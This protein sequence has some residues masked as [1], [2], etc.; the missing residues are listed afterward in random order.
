MQ[1]SK[2]E[3]RAREMEEGEKESGCGYQTRKI[4]FVLWPRKMKQAL[5]PEGETLRTACTIATVV[6]TLMY[7]M[8]IAVVGFTPTVVN[9]INAAFAYSCKLTLRER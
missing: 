3:A 6:H 9:L 4:F 2:A 5:T 8:C 7:L 1:E